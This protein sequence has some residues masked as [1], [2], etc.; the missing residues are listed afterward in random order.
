MEKVTKG[1]SKKRLT[2][3]SEKIGSDKEEASSKEP[4][5]KKVKTTTSVPVNTKMPEKLEFHKPSGT[6]KLA[7][8]NVSGLKAAL[9]KGYHTYVEAEDADIL[10]LQETKV[11]E[12]EFNAIDTKKYKYHW[13]GFEEKKG[14][15]GVAVFSKIEP[16]SVAF[17]LSTH[18]TP[19]IT[20][21]RVITLEFK[22]LYY[23]AVYVPNAG[24]K[25]VRLKERVTWDEAMERYLRQLDEKKP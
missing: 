18:P 13:W 3:E 5:L 6:V 11:N 14:Y 10:C 23:V 7:S 25:L 22:T 24:E 9:K 8:W 20:K 15:G 19:E 2:E 17:G 4:E 16:I 1:N 21:G 12:K